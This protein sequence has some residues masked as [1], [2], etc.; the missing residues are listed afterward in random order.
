MK[1][2]KISV[3][4]VT[5]FL[6]FGFSKA[7]LYEEIPE[8]FP[9]LE[10]SKITPFQKGEQL[11]YLVHYGLIN[12]GEAKLT[13]KE[14]DT[15]IDGKSVF[16]MYGEGKTLSVF[17]WFYTVRDVYETYLDEKTL[18]PRK[19]RRRVN[20][21]GYIIDRDYHFV[22]EKEKVNTLRKGEIKT[23]KDVQ[24]MLSSFYYLRAFDFT[25]AKPGQIFKINAF[26]DYKMFPFYVKYVG[27]D[28]VKVGMGKYK[29]IKFVPVVQEGRVFKSEDDLEI[30][31]TDDA[32]KV[33][34]LVKANL[35]VGSAKAELVNYKN[36]K[37]VLPKVEENKWLGIF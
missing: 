32:A 34:V 4:L 24:D 21:G 11:T 19:F 3:L 37:T 17:E 12:A 18:A 6:L 33:P 20:E 30:W 7:I 26:M 8:S 14:Q 29:C 16:H 35:F 9:K 5:L 31:V 10:K 36:V 15:I 25:N 13:V 27:K 28:E 1:A 22:P 23:P 2:F